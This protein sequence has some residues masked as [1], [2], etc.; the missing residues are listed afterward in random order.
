MTSKTVLE[1]DHDDNMASNIKRHDFPNDFFFGVGSSAYQVY[2]CLYTD[3]LM[4]T[5]KKSNRWCL[6]V[7]S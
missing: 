4:I 2:I 7:I 5:N 3:T 1:F 6:D